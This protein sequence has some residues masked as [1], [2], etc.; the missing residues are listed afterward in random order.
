MTTAFEEHA[1][2]TV[3]R[4][5]LAIV[6]MWPDLLRM[7]DRS[8]SKD[9]SGVRAKPGSRPPIDLHVSDV[10]AEVTSWVYF[11]A[12][13]LQDEVVVERDGRAQPWSPAVAAMPQM[14]EEIARWR[15]GHFTEHEDEML[16]L[17]I[18]DDAR[19]FES[20]VRRVAFPTGA[21]RVDLRVPC[22]EYETDDLG[23]RIACEG[24]YF[25]I[26]VPDKPLGDMICSMDR[27]HR[28]T[29]MEWQRAARRGLVEMPSDAAGTA[30]R[31]V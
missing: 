26:L 19:A 25:T 29:P 21:R 9:E 20:K 8:G 24:E 23:Q 16:A 12:R 13:T 3:Q 1:S 18:A 27:A 10:I 17:A 7:L 6:S 4:D 31:A 28:M 15:V 30:P 5:M 22:L 2:I 11:L 14:L